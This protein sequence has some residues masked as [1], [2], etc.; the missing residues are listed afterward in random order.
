MHTKLRDYRLS[1]LPT[2]ENVTNK[3]THFRKYNISHKLGNVYLFV[4]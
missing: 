2:H 1:I 3:Q 4:E